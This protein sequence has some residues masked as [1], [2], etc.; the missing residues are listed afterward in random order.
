[1]STNDENSE[2]KENN[3]EISQDS[4]F[5]FF[6]IILGCL[7]IFGGL[8]NA[9]ECSEASNYYGKRDEY[10][11]WAISCFVLCFNCFF[12]AHII[13]ILANSRW[14]LNQIYQNSLPQKS[15]TISHP[16]VIDELK[17]ISE[18]NKAQSEALTKSIDEFS[19]K[20][21][22]TNAYLYHIL[23]NMK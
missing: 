9:S 6:F 13:S 16:R 12:A 3:L 8:F 14:L 10:A 19:D 15:D 1:M 20:T 17:K 23:S 18:Q 21:E 4:G 2:T 7:F 11:I 5:A 22:K